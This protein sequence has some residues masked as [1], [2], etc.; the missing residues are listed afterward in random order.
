MKTLRITSLQVGKPRTVGVAG[1][2]EVMDREWTTAFYKTPCDGPRAVGEMGIDGDGQA[3]L[4]NHGGVDKAVCVYPAEHYSFWAAGLGLDLPWGAFGENLSV[5]GL[6][7][8]EVRIGDVYECGELCLQVSQPR[9]PCWKLARRWRVKDLAAQVERTGRTGWYFRVLSPG[10]LAAGDV[11]TLQSEGSEW[12]VARSNEI[13]HHHKQDWEAAAALADCDLL[14]TSWKTS[15]RKRS[16]LRRSAND[17][18][19]KEQP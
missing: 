11:L 10:T 19:R 3:D 8:H 12:S 17:A 16:E 5:E 7:E 18:L 4:V 1:A 14:S 2:A 9:Q 6:L 15:L 13:M